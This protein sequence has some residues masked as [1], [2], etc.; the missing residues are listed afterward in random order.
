MVWKILKW[1]NLDQKWRDH[2]F[3]LKLLGKNKGIM[4]IINIQYYVSKRV[5]I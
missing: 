5:K 2:N 3:Y 1:E 4:K